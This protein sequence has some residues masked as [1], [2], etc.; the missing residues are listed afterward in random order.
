MLAGVQAEE[1]GRFIRS[2]RERLDPEAVGLPGGGGRRTPGLRREELAVSAG[3][4]A[5][6]LARI[7]QGRA[8]RVSVEVLGALADALRLDPTER[9]HLFG[10]AGARAPGDGSS[11]AELA[12]EHRRLVAALDPNPA[13][14]LDREWRVVAWNA[15]EE[16]LFPVLATIGSEPHLLRLFL[17]QSRLRRDIE[18]WPDEIRRLVR[19]LRAH[20]AD[21]PSPALLEE[22][23]ELRVSH[24]EFA[25]AWERRDVG[26]LEPHRRVIRAP[27]GRRVY[28]QHRLPLPDRPG[29][30][31]VL[32]V[33]ITAGR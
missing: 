19:H 9:T 5:S 20:V 30:L 7:E 10:L 28:E 8:R 6:W 13:Y 21:H 15:A 4:G 31:L 18:D 17:E 24:P 26:P 2:R 12:A 1:L 23:E 11:P 3:V 33:E 29:W 27:T 16:A 32:F 22:I 25:D 14:I